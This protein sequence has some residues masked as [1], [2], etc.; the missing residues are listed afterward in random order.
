MAGRGAGAHSGRAP[1][2]TGAPDSSRLILGWLRSYRRSWLAADLTTGLLIVAVA[3]PLSMGMAEVAGMPPI[4]GL[5]SCMLPLVGYALVGSSRHLVLGL[6]ASTAALIA[7]AVAPMAIG[8][9]ERYA[10]LAAVI[11]LLVGLFAIVGG[12]LRLGVAANLLSAPALLGYQAGLAVTVIVNQLPRLA[13]IPGS[14]GGT[15][16]RVRTIIQ[17]IDDVS[18]TTLLVGLGGIAIMLG[19]RWWRPRIPGALIAVVIV[20]LVVNR[21][22]LHDDV[23]TIGAIPS[24]LPSLRWPSIRAGDLPRLASA[25]LGITLVAA[26]DTVAAS[27]AFAIRGR[28]R[29]DA[30]RE[31]AGLGLANALSGV[32]GGITVSASAARTAIAE[33]AGAHT[34]L[35]SV[36]SA[37][38]LGL[39]L[40]WLTGPLESVPVTALAGVVIVAVARIIDVRALRRLAGTRPFEFVLALATMIGVVAVG[41]LEGI[42]LAV[43]LSLVDFVRRAARPHDAVLG[44]GSGRDFVDLDV[45]PDAHVEPGLVLFRFDAPLFHANIDRF[46]ERIEE[47]L[48]TTDPRPEWIVID[49]SPITDIDATAA[50]ALGELAGEWAEQGITLAFAHLAHPVRELLGTYGFGPLLGPDHQFDS[51][52]DAVAAFRAR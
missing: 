52:T 34:P 21:A 41:V 40:V 31:L 13:G 49:G 47:L 7:A 22:G 9:A 38:I 16:R 50:D 19:V 32:S 44:R 10:E 18:T 27:R 6:D 29:V 48:A 45:A 4:V 15:V 26:A 42:V 1:G 37:A 35:A 46:R 36:S 12:L 5:Y 23:A 25:A 3:I 30:N 2:P 28:Y 24:G 20:T 11:A 51:V 8:D 39:V 33:S 43:V 17:Q 14:G